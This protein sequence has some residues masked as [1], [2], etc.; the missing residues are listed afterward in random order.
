MLAH[1]HGRMADDA[2]DD[3][4]VNLHVEQERYDG[5]AA[6]MPVPVLVVGDARP[7]HEVAETG[8]VIQRGYRESFARPE[9]QVVRVRDDAL[10]GLQIPVHDGA[11][12]GDYRHDLASRGL[13]RRQRVPLAQVYH[14]V[15]VRHLPPVSGAARRPFETA[16]VS[17][18]PAGLPAPMLLVEAFQFPVHRVGAY[19]YLA[20][21]RC[22]QRLVPPQVEI[23][24]CGSQYLPLPHAGEQTPPLACAHEQV[25]G[26]RFEHVLHLLHG[27][28]LAVLLA[29]AL[30]RR[31]DHG[32]V[33]GAPV[34]G[35]SRVPAFRPCRA[36][37]GT[38]WYQPVGHRRLEY[39]V[40]DV[41]ETQLPVV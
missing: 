6:F 34:P 19:P 13:R 39:L 1:F 20:A 30:V 11:Q 36:G 12:L 41:V 38:G 3:A 28:R 21:V 18:V 40:Q 22:L 15:S 29:A 35:Q 24:Q 14:V 16:R 25:V 7:A 8:P 5:I 10:R 2:L 26:G 23:V 9:Y 4:G 17:S 37:D 33:D 32:P 27:E 31:N